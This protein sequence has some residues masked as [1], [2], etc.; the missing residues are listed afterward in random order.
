ML[1]RDTPEELPSDKLELKLFRKSPLGT[2]IDENCLSPLTT[3]EILYQK[4]SQAKRMIKEKEELRSLANKSYTMEYSASPLRTVHMP[5]IKVSYKKNKKKNL[6]VNSSNSEVDEY[7]PTDDESHLFPEFCEV[8]WTRLDCVGW[9][10]ESSQQLSMVVV[11]NKVFLIGGISRSIIGDVNVFIPAYK[12]WEKIQ[13]I[14]VESEPRFGHS[15]VEYKQK[16]YL[17]GG[18]TDFNAVHKLRECL[19]GVKVLNTE[20]FEISNLKCSGSYITTRKQHCCAIVGKH[21]FIH[22]GMNQ[23]N[24]LLDDASILNLEKSH[25]KLL[26]IK[27]LGPGYC[28]FHTAVTILHPSQKPASSIYK[29]PNLK[30]N[31]ETHTGIYIFGGINRERKATNNLFLLKIGTKQLTWITPETKGTP[32][33]PRFQHSMSYNEKLDILVIFGGRVDIVNTQHYTCFNDVFILRIQDWTWITIK[34]LGNVPTPRSGHASVSYG[35]KIYVF[36]GVGTS[37]YCSSNLYVLEL[38]QKTARHLI[39]DEERRKAKELEVETMRT[40]RVEFQQEERKKGG[41]RNS[42]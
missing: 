31:Q 33:S 28:G 4:R 14:G 12:R 8:F 9:K 26:S 27:G 20:N 40:K 13:T 6:D 41:F 37:A 1:E 16:I 24:N 29:L 10:P 32:P 3:R 39:E 5:F 25:W 36:G 19:N 22:G 21:M 7:L 38:N 35:T 23:K 2:R 34:V 15:T 11:Q 17:F 18:G 30:K 42:E